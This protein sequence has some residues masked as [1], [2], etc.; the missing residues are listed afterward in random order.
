MS[1]NFTKAKLTFVLVILA[2]TALLAA[3]PGSAPMPPIILSGADAYKA[4]GAEAAVKAWLKGSPLEH[5]KD[6]LRQAQG[7]EVFEEYYGKFVGVHLIVQRNLTE[8]T[9]V[10]FVTLDFEK[11]PVFCKFLLYKIDKDWVVISFLFNTKD[12]EILPQ[13]TWEDLR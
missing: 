3:T 9:K 6:A 13:W 5:Q 2:S 7:M 4:E 10:V 12:T 11:G 8:T 1:R